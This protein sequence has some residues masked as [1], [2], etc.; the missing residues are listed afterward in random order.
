MKKERYTVTM[1]FY[2]WA[3]D[4]ANAMK[5]AKK[6]VRRMEKAEDNQPVLQS[7][8]RTPFATMASEPIFDRSMPD[9][10]GAKGHALYCKTIIDDAD[11]DK[12]E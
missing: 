7:L 5:E 1:D 10:G 11:L 8:H 12:E 3:D 2:I 9:N 4:D 6:R